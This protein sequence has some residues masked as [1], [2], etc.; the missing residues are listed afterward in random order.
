[1]QEKVCLVV[2]YNHPFVKNVDKINKLYGNRFD[3]I[4][5]IMPYYRGNNVDIIPVYENSYQ[6][7]GYIAQAFS[8]IYHDEFSYYVFMGDDVLMRPDFSKDTMLDMLKMDENTGYIARNIFVMNESHLISK[9]WLFPTLL[10]YIYDEDKHE[11]DGILPDVDTMLDK[12]KSLGMTPSLISENKL[13][14]L[15]DFVP[16]NRKNSFFY[17]YDLRTSLIDCAKLLKNYVETNSALNYVFPFACGFSD[18][19]AIPAKYFKRFAY[20]SGAMAAK[21]IFA[22]VAIPTALAICLDKLSMPKDIK[23]ATVNYPATD[24]RRNELPDKYNHSVK[25]LL[26]DWDDKNLLLHPVKY[27]MWEMDID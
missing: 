9:I 21:R 4:Y 17:K 25:K 26:A 10:S 22:E 3:K 8:S 27:S 19:F 16:V 13:R 23:Y 11:L 18:F 15:Q 5:H 2:I 1:M 20:I 6:F 14:Y 24:A 7:Q 12:Y